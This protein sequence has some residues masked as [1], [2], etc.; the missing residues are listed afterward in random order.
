MHRHFCLDYM[1][2]QLEIDA[3]VVSDVVTSLPQWAAAGRSG[4]SPESGAVTNTELGSLPSQE[5]RL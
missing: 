1:R 3:G 4:G 2:T 5:A